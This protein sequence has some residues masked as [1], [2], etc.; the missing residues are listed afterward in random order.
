MG[1]Q[2]EGH[3]SSFLTPHLQLIEVERLSPTPY[4]LGKTKL[5]RFGLP[6]SHPPPLQPCQLPPLLPTPQFLSSSYILYL[7]YLFRRSA[8]SGFNIVQCRLIIHSTGVCR[9]DFSFW[10]SENLKL[11]A[12]SALTGLRNLI[13][14]S[15]NVLL[16]V[17]VRLLTKKLF[18]MACMREM[19]A[20]QLFMSKMKN[21]LRFKLNFKHS[22]EV[23]LVTTRRIFDWCP[24]TFVCKS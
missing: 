6:P 3:G 8:S 15:T 9:M 14:S 18:S 12:K 5:P 17:L 21:I 16:A 2:R 23:L 22:Q 24:R 13:H 11:V 7:S 10:M 20:R 4:M 19:N 1:R